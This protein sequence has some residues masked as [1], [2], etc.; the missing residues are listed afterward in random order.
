MRARIGIQGV[1]STIKVVED[2]YRDVLSIYKVGIT[3]LK[4]YVPKEFINILL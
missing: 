4:R 3:T 2:C 1:I